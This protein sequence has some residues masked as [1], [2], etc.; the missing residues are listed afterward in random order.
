MNRF[1]PP[2]LLLILWLALLWPAAAPAA[3]ADL[4]PA[5]EGPSSGLTFRPPGELRRVDA[6]AGEIARYSA[7]PDAG[8][9]V[10]RRVDLVGDGLP[11]QT[12][13]LPPQSPLNPT[14]APLKRP[15][16]LDV[17]ATEVLGS[18]PGEVL[19]RD[20][21]LVNNA[22]MG[23]LVADTQGVT[24]RRLVQVALVRVSDRVY[25][26][27]TYTL[28]AEQDVPLHEQPAL[29]RAAEVF[30]DVI[31]TTRLVDR[32]DVRADQD[33]RLIRTRGLLVNWTEAK[34]RE[35]LKP[36]SWVM[37]VQEDT[38]IGYTGT[39][40]GIGEN[41]PDAAALLDPDR[42][43]EGADGTGIQVCTRSRLFR[44]DGW[45][46]DSEFRSFATFG[47]ERERW[48][49]LTTT[50]TELDGER[51]SSFLEEVG[52]AAKRTKAVRDD[53]SADGVSLTQE[54]LLTVNRGTSDGREPELTRELP[55]FY[56]PQAFAA[57]LPQLIPLDRPQTYLFAQWVPEQSEIMLRYIDVVGEQEVSLAGKSVRGIVIEDRLGLEGSRTKHLFDPVQ[58]TY[59]GSV[60][61]EAKLSLV[62]TTEAEIAERLGS[63]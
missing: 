16:F 18:T 37:L 21:I 51:K 20:T 4:G 32:S 56:L 53:D 5:F 1:L 31:D 57:L 47:R 62:P 49:S 26:R 45:T 61:E 44:D 11:L 8:T 25:Y 13:T 9:F 22:E 39:F 46:I 63:E 17:V 6:R 38:P 54:F 19:R 36:V 40:T 10:V 30:N 12:I 3:P 15:G 23:V 2:S 7:G 58:H 33:E 55:E 29:L 48:T 43:I 52:S 50:S 42:N 27:M 59:L 41:L 60:N 35:Q 34:L 24:G 14:D 28:P